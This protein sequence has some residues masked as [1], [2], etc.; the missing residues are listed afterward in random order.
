MV[1]LQHSFARH[2]LVN[3]CS[4][5]AVPLSSGLPCICYLSRISLGSA[6]ACPAC[7]VATLL[8]SASSSSDEANSSDSDSDDLVSEAEDGVSKKQP[9]A[10]RAAGKAGKGPQGSTTSKEA[11]GGPASY[12]LEAAMAAA[13]EA[14]RK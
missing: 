4:P 13:L 11:A 7:T 8:P 3:A 5:L 10:G 9:G 12:S 6:D 2:Q 1:C 14:L